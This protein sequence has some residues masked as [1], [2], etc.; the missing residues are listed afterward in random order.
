MLKALRNNLPELIWFLLFM[1]FALTLNTQLLEAS[2]VH[3]AIAGHDEYLTVRQVYSILHPG[4][5]KHFI[6]AVIAGEKLYY[7]RIMFYTD[8]LCAFIPYKI[9][10]VSGMILA[11][12]M[13]HALILAFSLWV[14]GKTFL[15]K[16]VYRLLFLIL[17]TIGFYT[18]YFIMMPKPEP[19]QLLFLA[20]FLKYWKKNEWRPGK[21]FIWLGMAYGAK[22]SIL[23]A[24]PFIALVSLFSPLRPATPRATTTKIIPTSIKAM[25]WFLAGLIIAIP[26]LILIPVKPIVLDT[27]IKHTFLG[28]G[29]IDD[30]PSVTWFQW[31]FDTYGFYYWGYKWMSW[32]FLAILATV[33]ILIFRYKKD[34]GK[35]TE[36]W[37]LLLIAT[38]MFFP[39]IFLTQRLWPHYI[40]EGHTLFILL[41]L[42]V[43]TNHNLVSLKKLRIALT[44]VLFAG[45]AFFSLQFLFVH[46][47]KYYKLNDQYAQNRENWYKVKNH[48]VSKYPNARVIQDMS[49]YFPF[50]EFVRINPYHPFAGKHPEEVKTPSFSWALPDHPFSET[51]TSGMDIL[52]LKDMQPENKTTESPNA[53]QKQ[54]NL[55]KNEMQKSIGNLW[56]QDTVI[57]GHFVYVKRTQ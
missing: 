30:D 21:S 19:Y 48:I 25:G 44:A 43:L 18:N 53:L 56:L 28:S 34:K 29:Q 16:N 4:S 40:W 13:A 17:A 37:P 33:T 42:A 36:E 27:Y 39:V 54:N 12:R 24:L 3:K 50:R 26:C 55:W 11:I 7:G 47:K 1:V 49:V 31:L 9:W 6:M 41:F 51:E 35:F 15:Q 10:G 57:N 20:V 5:F 8:A 22:F 14:L 52:V 38:A 46:L 45:L 32:L 23:F 2:N